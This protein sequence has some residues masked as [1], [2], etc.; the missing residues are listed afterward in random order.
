MERLGFMDVPLT[1]NE[2][3]VLE[4]IRGYLA[5]RGYS[6]S[7]EEIQKA[8]GYRSVN[9]VQNYVKQLKA[10]N[11]LTQSAKHKRSLALVDSETEGVIPILGKV[12][13]GKPLQFSDHLGDLKFSPYRPGNFFALQVVG[14]SMIEEGIFD[15]DWVVVKKANSASNGELVVASVDEAATIKRIFRR[16]QGQNLVLELKAANPDFPSQFYSPDRVRVEGIVTHLI[17]K[18][19]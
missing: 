13:A 17:R 19:S 4:F 5:R 9:S 15:G 12:A 18:F 2:K 11:Y 6:P 14:L 8:F 7:Y 16:K 10:K 3:K 1:P